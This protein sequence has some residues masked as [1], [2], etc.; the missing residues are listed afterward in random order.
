M[1][2][3]RIMSVAGIVLLVTGPPCLAGSDGGTYRSGVSG[4]IENDGDIEVKEGFNLKFTGHG[5]NSDSSGT[6]TIDHATGSVQF[7]HTGTDP[8]QIQT[9]EVFLHNGLLNMD[10]PL[11]FRGKFEMKPNA[12][13]NTEDLTTDQVVKFCQGLCSL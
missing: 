13:V 1:K 9:A 4:D 8:V 10:K 6:I 2:L 5:L 3:L 7:A 12:T 11:E